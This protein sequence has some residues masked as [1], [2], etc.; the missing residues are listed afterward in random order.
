[1]DKSLVGMILIGTMF[2]TLLVYLEMDAK[3]IREEE[4]GIKV[5]AELRDVAVYDYY[6]SKGLIVEDVLERKNG[7]YLVTMESGKSIVVKVDD[8]Y[9]VEELV[10]G[11]TQDDVKGRT[12][13]K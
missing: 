4:N 2:V 13:R 10:G 9:K 7:T 6:D 3:E 12:N 1:M 5:E 11:D 8:S